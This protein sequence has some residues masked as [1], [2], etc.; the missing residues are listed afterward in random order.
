M[1]SNS[2]VPEHVFVS[3]SL[4]LRRCIR[5]LAECRR[6]AWFLA[7][8]GAEDLKYEGLGPQKTSNILGP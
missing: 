6:V 1:Q 7:A 8:L 2:D 4:R 5:T 3:A